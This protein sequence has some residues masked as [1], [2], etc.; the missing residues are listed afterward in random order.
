MRRTLG[1]I[2]GALLTV[3]VQAQPGQGQPAFSRTEQRQPCADYDP[4][5]R[6]FFGD[7]HVHTAWSFDASGQDTRNTPTDAYRFAV[8]GPMRIQ[9]YDENGRGLRE[10]RIDR[11]LDFAAVT[12]HSE[13]FG[14]MRLCASEGEAGYSH[15]VCRVHRNL[16]ALTQLMFGGYGLSMK[17]RWGLCGE[18]GS[19][20]LDAAGDTW[21]AVQDAAEAA[22][23]RSADCSFT[24]FVGYEWTATVGRGRNLHH[25]VIFRN[26]KVPDHPLSWIESPSQVQLWDYLEQDCVAANPGCDAIAIPH[27][28]NLSGGLAFETARLSSA[29]IPPEPV[30]AAEAARRAH[31]NPLLELMQ[32]K[33]SSECDSRLPTW[34]RDEY[35]AFEK[36]PYDNFGTKNTGEDGSGLLYVLKLLFGGQEYREVRLPG[37]SSF[38]RYALKQGLQQQRELGVNSFKYGLIASTDTHIA[39]PGLVMEMNHPGHG[40]AGMG[41]RD[42]VLPLP[43]ELEFN[44]GGL[45]VLYAEENS[46]DALF[47]AM[48][49]REAYATS[50]TRPTLRFFGGW[51]YPAQACDAPDMVA[52]G[53]ARGVPMGGDLPAAPGRAAPRF[54]VSVQA[55]AG[56][57]EYPGN[58]LQRVQIVKG[59]YADGELRERVLDVAGGDNGARVD[60]ATCEQSG[61][62][63]QHLCAV[64]QDP[65]FDPAAPAFYYARALENPACRWSQHVCVDAGVDCADPSS[66][67][68]ALQQCCAEQHI[69]VIQERAWSSPI[70][71]TPPP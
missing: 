41:A 54:L 39:A 69:R 10:I 48:R 56:T 20:C 71:Y 12:D 17:R 14:E 29:E 6:A 13:F 44:P 35:C 53:Y 5:R 60:P 36:L 31:W 1:T 62:G 58:L 51:D 8:G 11:P 70:W 50:G 42:D 47:A 55:D 46:R 52:Q 2:F 18:D 40:G 25:N 27:N 65:D 38:V 16:P 61:P 66:V 67:P 43:D 63:H 34:S 49:R 21:R 59:W 33:G 37:E 19:V 26:D 7:T 64:W 3:A 30:S 32:H 57:P 23:D 24:S 68:E 9:P 45:A 15:P 22:Y 4:L 28:T